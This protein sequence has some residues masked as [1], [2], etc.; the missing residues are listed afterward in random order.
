MRGK[1][2]LWLGGVMLL[3]LICIAAIFSRLGKYLEAPVQFPD[4]ADLIVALGG[5]A[6]ER[7]RKALELYKASYAP[8][9]LITGVEGGDELTRPHYLNWRAAFLVEHGV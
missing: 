9:V 6:G 8:Y 4:K 2:F 5:D 3:F 1:L 7:V